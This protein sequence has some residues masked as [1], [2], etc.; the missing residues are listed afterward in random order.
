MSYYILHYMGTNGTKNAAVPDA[1]LDAGQRVTNMK[2]ASKRLELQHKHGVAVPAPVPAA[3]IRVDHVLNA[4]NA[5]PDEGGF[6]RH[7]RDVHG[8]TYSQ[9]GI[10]PGDSRSRT[11][12]SSRRFSPARSRCLSRGNLPAG[13]LPSQRFPHIR[14]V[15][16][17]GRADLE[18][19]SRPGQLAEDGVV[20][21]LAPRP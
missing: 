16:P 13:S 21:G 14:D 1:Q 4:G 17:R 5:G 6:G 8:G 12:A 9:R 11:L 7:F 3:G 10:G 20:L 18:V 2:G 15:V 19:P